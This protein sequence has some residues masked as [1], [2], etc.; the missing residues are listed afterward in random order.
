MS[1]EQK[2]FFEAGRRAERERILGL[3]TDLKTEFGTGWDT[4]YS[5]GFAKAIAECL[6]LVKGE[7]E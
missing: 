3:L 1:M 4:V 2:Q 7:N 6:A 5:E